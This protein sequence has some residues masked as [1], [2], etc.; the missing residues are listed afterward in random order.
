VTSFVGRRR[1][2]AATRRLLSGSRLLTL[3]GVAGVGKTRLAVRMATEVRRTFDDGVWFVELGAL[4]DPDLLGHTL[5]E[6]LDL[7][8]VSGSPESDVAEFLEDKDLLLVL[9]KL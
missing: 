2:L 5:A 4:R 6:A 1:E 7:I 9:D 8:Q 3:T